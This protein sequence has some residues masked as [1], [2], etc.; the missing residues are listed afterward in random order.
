MIGIVIAS[1][2][3][4]AEGMYDAL[5]MFSGEINQIECVSL[6][7]DE[8]L[9]DFSKR[10]KS[11]IDNVDSGDGAIVFCDLLY[12]TPSNVAASLLNDENYKNRVEVI[13]GI[14]LATILEFTNMRDENIDTSHL[15]NVGRKGMESIKNIIK[16]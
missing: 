14:N 7:P 9:V 12:G 3:K 5:I 4:F 15:L 8:N 2:G 16:H 10:I 1:H 6:N 13:S 11:A